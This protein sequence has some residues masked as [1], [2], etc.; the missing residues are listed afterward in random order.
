MRGLCTVTETSCLLNERFC[1]S[2]QVRLG[3]RIG[4][5]LVYQ[6]CVENLK[7]KKNSKSVQ[8][9]GALW[10]GLTDFPHHNRWCFVKLIPRLGE[11]GI[12]KSVSGGSIL[13]FR[14]TGHLTGK[15]RF[16][17]G[18]WERRHYCWCVCVVLTLK[19][20]CVFPSK[21]LRNSPK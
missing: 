16:H 19:K 3:V 5:F 20:W 15:S 6:I 8:R 2:Q 14:N 18:S 21:L 11:G 13:I 9:A 4:I 7:G 1:N 12:K 17:L 10:K